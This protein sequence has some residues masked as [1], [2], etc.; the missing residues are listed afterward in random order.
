MQLYVLSRSYSAAV[1]GVEARLVT[2]EAEV[3]MGLPCLTLVGQLS[4]A[5]YEG[6]ERVKSALSH[7]GHAVAPRRQVVNL[8]PAQLRKDSSGLDL[9]IAMALLAAHGVVDPQSLESSLFWAEL[10]LDGVLRPVSGALLVADLARKQKI[11]RVFV[12]PECGGEAALIPG[13]EVRTASHLSQL[14][15]FLRGEGELDRVQPQELEPSLPEESCAPDMADVRGLALARL[16]LE[17]MVAGGHNFLMWGP[18]GVGKTMLARRARGLFPPLDESAAIERTKIVSVA[19]RKLVTRLDRSVPLR[20]P[21]HS[22]SAAGLLG[23]G[24]PVRPGEVSLAHRGLLFLD[25]LPEFSRSCIEGLREPIEEGMVHVVRSE[26]SF[27]FPAQFQ[28]LAAMNP[29]PCGFYG[30]PVRVCTCSPH[31]VSRY[32][33]KISGPFLDRM[34][35]VVALTAAPQSEDSSG[36]TAKAEDSASI[37]ARIQEARSRQQARYREHNCSSNATVPAVRGLLEELCP[38]HEKAAR[39]LSAAAQRGSISLRVQQRLHKVA[40]SLC[41]L[42]PE[43][44]TQGKIG[45]QAVALAL[46]LRRPLRS[47]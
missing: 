19:T 41:D 34:D 5:V 37:R 44:R 47:Y 27:R 2:V 10:G 23:G 35:L 46:Q 11:R 36:P 29:C 16:A 17:V 25:E 32:Q 21:H 7:C 31:T 28:L 43:L 8:A 39:L 12:A 20:A 45:E 40:Q 24:R 4:G 9:P 15:A 18:P 33:Q 13:V 3:S 38:M 6:R 22:V 26:G 1:L 42:R 14:S 30:D